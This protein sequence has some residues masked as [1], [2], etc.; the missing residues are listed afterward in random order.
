MWRAFS[1]SRP[2]AHRAGDALS[3]RDSHRYSRADH[4]PDAHAETIAH[5]ETDAQ[6]YA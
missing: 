5:T 6:A 1:D 4:Q 2:Y 3:N